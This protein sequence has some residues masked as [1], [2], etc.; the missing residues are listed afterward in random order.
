MPQRVQKSRRARPLGN[1]TYFQARPMSSW[2]TVFGWVEG[3][4]GVDQPTIDAS[5]REFWRGV[6]RKQ[7][8]VA[9]IK[10]FMAYPFLLGFDHRL[11]FVLECPSGAPRPLEC[12]IL[13]H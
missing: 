4:F 3:H 10:V 12:C 2:R 13:H 6:G 11:V 1:R 7:D 8:G 5:P 9:V